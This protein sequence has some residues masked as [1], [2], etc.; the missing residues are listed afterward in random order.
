MFDDKTEKEY[1][2]EIRR[3]SRLARTYVA[4]NPH[5]DA[6]VQFNIGRKVNVIGVV[7]DALKSGLMSANEDGME[8]L[9]AM[10]ALGD[11]PGMPSI[12]MVQ[13]AIE[14]MEEIQKEDE[15]GR[16]GTQAKA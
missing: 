3:L 10:G 5:S 9:K 14:Y 15:D 12:M 11:K 1:F 7:P 13:A 16:R 6:K 4:E 8:M 2:D